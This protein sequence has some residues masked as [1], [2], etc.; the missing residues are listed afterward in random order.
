MTDGAACPLAGTVELADSCPPDNPCLYTEHDAYGMEYF[1]WPAWASCLALLP[2]SA[3]C[4]LLY[5]C[6]LAEH[7][8]LKDR[9]LIF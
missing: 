2:G 6:S 5:T 9:S 4:Q 3:S 1:R 7:G 8:E